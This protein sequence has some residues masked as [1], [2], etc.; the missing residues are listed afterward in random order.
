MPRPA[1][2][3]LERLGVESLHH[4]TIHAIL[5]NL[6]HLHTLVSC[7]PAADM[8]LHCSTNAMLAFPRRTL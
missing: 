2:T 1:P 6:P 5:D 3:G 8:P 4:C 7:W